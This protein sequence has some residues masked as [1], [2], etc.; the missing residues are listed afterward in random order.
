MFAVSTTA[1][2]ASMSLSLSTDLDRLEATVASFTKVPSVSSV[3]SPPYF[4]W[5]D[6]IFI[7]LSFE[8][9]VDA[10]W[11]KAFNERS[12]SVEE[13]LPTSTTGTKTSDTSSVN[14]QT[15]F[16]T[17]SIPQRAP[18]LLERAVDT[19]NQL[20]RQNFIFFDY[21]TKEGQARQKAEL[22]LRDLRTQMSI[23]QA[24]RPLVSTA[25]DNKPPAA[26]PA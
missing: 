24:L 6:E 17:S 16:K 13:S 21:W 23:L 3:T 20:S 26:K 1:S 19:C 10:L 18:S 12:N 11:D 7:T 22:Q 2:S 4:F 25:H 14:S 9:E 5:E 8:S 15:S